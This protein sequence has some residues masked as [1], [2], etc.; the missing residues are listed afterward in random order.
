MEQNKTTHT[1][2][3][4]QS[5]AASV[6]SDMAL[7]ELTPKEAIELI[8]DFDGKSIGVE[9]F[10]TSI[11]D[12]RCQVVRQDYFRRLIITKKIVGDAGREIQ[13]YEIETYDKLYDALRILFGN[14][15]PVSVWRDKRSRIFQGKSESVSKFTHRFLEVQNKVLAVLA[16]TITDEVKRRFVIE[17]ERE[18]GLEQYLLGLQKEISIEVRAQRPEN[19]RAAIAKAQAVEA[20]N[21]TREV[22]TQNLSFAERNLGMHHRLSHSSSKPPAPSSSTHRQQ[23]ACDYCQR[24]GHLERDCRKK[25]YDTERKSNNAQQTSDFHERRLP[26][27]PPPR[28]NHLQEEIKKREETDPSLKLTKSDPLNELLDYQCRTLEEQDNS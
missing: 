12:V 20:Y 27:Q 18:Q 8:K 3:N 19:I 14:L 24:I 16:N 15:Q 21:Y 7:E 22:M 1:K 2:E 5:P 17:Y 6:F 11:E 28:I 13:Q 25:I 26:P 4:D 9:T 10:I 23:V